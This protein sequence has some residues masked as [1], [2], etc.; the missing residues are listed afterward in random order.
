LCEKTAISVDLQA[1]KLK[2]VFVDLVALL[3][4]PVIKFSSGKTQNT[5]LYTVMIT[6]LGWL[7]FP[8]NQSEAQVSTMTHFASQ[9]CP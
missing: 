3:E 5:A 8:R 6:M 2:F 4:R 7:F 9:R 1:L